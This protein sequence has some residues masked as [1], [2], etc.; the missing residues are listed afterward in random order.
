MTHGVVHAGP[1]CEGLQ[2]LTRVVIFATYSTR[3]MPHYDIDFQYK[4]WD[5]AFYAE[6]PAMV[7]YRRLSEVHTY[8]VSNHLNIQP[9]RHYTHERRN[10]CKALCTTDGL[11]EDD[12]QTLVDI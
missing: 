3:L 1:K 7:A 12:V 11:S 5:W 6:V 9:W 4:L 8:A 10:A 2:S